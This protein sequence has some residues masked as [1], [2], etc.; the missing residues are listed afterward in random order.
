ML[1]LKEHTKLLNS[2][3]LDS[4]LNIFRHFCNVLTTQCCS[5]TVKISITLLDN[6]IGKMTLPA[7][8]EEESGHKK[9]NHD[10][11]EPQYQAKTIV[12]KSPSKLFLRPLQSKMKKDVELAEE[13]W[14]KREEKRNEPYKIFH[15]SSQCP[16]PFF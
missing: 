13:T 15:N 10:D 8:P 7:V 6:I 14:A 9:D 4:E 11:E 16:C 1:I 12:G 5:Q 3:S 2:T